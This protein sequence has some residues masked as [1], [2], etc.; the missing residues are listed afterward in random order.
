MR[1][2]VCNLPSI[3]SRVP[4]FNRPALLVSRP[5]SHAAET[6][7]GP[8]IYMKYVYLCANAYTNMSA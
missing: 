3:L 7:N 8:N 2:N 6:A 5:L 4:K 1:I